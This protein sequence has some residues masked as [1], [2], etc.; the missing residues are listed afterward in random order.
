MMKP[1]IDMHCDTLLRCLGGESLA[2]MKGS[3]IDLNKLKD[4]GSLVQCLALFITTNGDQAHYGLG[5]KTA[6]QV[7]QAMLEVFHSQIAENRDRIKQ[8]FN[9][10]E[11]E[12]GIGGDKLMA[13]LTV[14]DAA[15]L[16]GK[17]ERIKEFYD[18][19]VRMMSLTWNY[20][21]CLAWPNSSDPLENNTKG[22]KPFGF[23]AVERM[24]DLGMIV[25]VSHLSDKG[26]WDVASVSEKPFIASHSCVRNLCSHQRNLTDDQLRALAEHGGIVGINFCGEFLE[27]GNRL[28]SSIRSVLQHMQYIK[29]V[30]GAETLAWGS[31]YDGIG[32][33]LEWQDFSGM[34]VLIDAMSSC[35]TDDEIEKICYKNF[36]R[37]LKDNE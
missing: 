1:I 9:S 17:L 15:P 8:I 24:N 18:D 3:H 2:A 6:Y 4:G 27:D 19:G 12:S 25:D 34:P 23:S 36:I 33:T 11:I 32:E 37:V 20:E 30:A 14:E 16:E 35:F 22:L 10:S 29:N 31:D 28:T 7:Y 26:F 5:D 13:L 21:N